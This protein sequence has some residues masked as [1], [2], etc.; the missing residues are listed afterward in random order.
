MEDFKRVVRYSK[1]NL[2]IDIEITFKDKRLS[3][4]GDIWEK[5]RGRWVNS[6]GG[7]C[8]EELLNEFPLSAPLV[9]LWQRWHLN[10]LNAG[11]AVQQSYLRALKNTGWKYTSYDY[12]CEQFKSVGLLVHD[13]YKYGS[14]WKF[15]K[16]P[17]RVLNE[18]KKMGES[19]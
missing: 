11:D 2:K 18:L 13:G 9:E 12:A 6:G 15:E 16:V 5:Q 8:Y 19:K 14:A 1:S 7:Q 3:I 10:D 4:S 17:A